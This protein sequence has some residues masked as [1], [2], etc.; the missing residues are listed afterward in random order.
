MGTKIKERGNKMQEGWNA[1]RLSLEQDNREMKTIDKQLYEI[2]HDAYCQGY[3]DGEESG[4]AAGWMLDV[5]QR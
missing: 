3:E 1:F 4:F 2:L 5:K